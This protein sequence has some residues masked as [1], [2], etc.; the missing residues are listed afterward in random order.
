MLDSTYKD[1]RPLTDDEIA[2][3]LIGLLLAGQHTSSTTSAWLGF[4]LARD[5]QLQERCYS[6]QKAVCG[7]HLPPLNYDQLKDLNLLDR[8]IRETLRLRPPIMT[9]MRMARTPR[10]WQ[11]TPFRQDIKCVCL[12]RLIK[13]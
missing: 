2:G 12:L 10:L 6:E 5:K 13:D 4:F 1:G 11:G 7:D 9:M 3:M 8:C